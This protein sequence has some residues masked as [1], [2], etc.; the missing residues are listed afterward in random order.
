MSSVEAE[1]FY[2]VFVVNDG[3][4]DV[5]GA[6]GGI[7]VYVDDITAEKSRILH[8]VSPYAAQHRA[9]RV[10]NQVTVDGD[11]LDGVL[12]GRLREAGPNV[13]TIGRAKN[14]FVGAMRPSTRSR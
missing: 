14:A 9:V 7:L 6:R 3:N 8:A 11:E 1:R 10:V 12:A 4:D 5:A 13:L 2:G